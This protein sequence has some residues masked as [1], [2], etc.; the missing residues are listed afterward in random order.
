MGV[1]KSFNLET[2]HHRK[3]ANAVFHDDSFL[4][5]A[6]TDRGIDGFRCRFSLLM[7]R[8]LLTATNAR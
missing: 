2:P 6:R 7:R 8:H 4:R 5:A 1:G 3:A